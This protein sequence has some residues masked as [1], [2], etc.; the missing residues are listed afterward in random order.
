MLDLIAGLITLTAPFAYVN[1]RF[2][3]LPTTIGVKLVA[4]VFSLVL[5][6]LDAVGIGHV[7]APASR[8]VGEVDFYAVV[9]WL[10]SLLLFAGAMHVKLDDLRH[11]WPIGIMASVGVVA[12]TFLA[13][14]GTYLV[15]DLIG[16]TIPF[17]YCL[18]FGA[19]IS[20]TDPIAVSI[21]K[22]ANA[23]KS[24]SENSV[25]HCLATVSR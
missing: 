4:L 18:V 10:L 21:L 22:S 11:K 19:L 24:R 20:P 13:G 2:I 5:V 16:L 25:N 3:G 14:A 15:L 7:G 1:H 9:I 12:S 17:I 23:Q 8:W 6:G